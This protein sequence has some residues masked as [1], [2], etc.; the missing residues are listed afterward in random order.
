M[1]TLHTDTFLRFRSMEAV[2][3]RTKT[4]FGVGAKTRFLLLRIVGSR[5][6]H[7]TIS[8]E[9]PDKYAVRCFSYILTCQEFRIIAENGDGLPFVPIPSVF[10]RLAAHLILPTHLLLS[11][12]FLLNLSH[13]ALH[14]SLR[15]MATGRSALPRRCVFLWAPR[16]DNIHVASPM[17]SRYRT[18]HPA[19]TGVPV[20][21][22]YAGIFRVLRLTQ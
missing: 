7:T 11:S 22:A 16:Y 1:L 9:G 3:C 6:T 18:L 15:P 8:Y 20:Q 2:A 19:T 13:A 17:Y 21:N 5:S 12:P 14:T 10:T 4:A